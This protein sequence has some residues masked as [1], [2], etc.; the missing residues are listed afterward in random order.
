MM[1]GVWHQ[2]S[3]RPE[4][5]SDFCRIVLLFLIPSEEQHQSGE[6]REEQLSFSRSPAVV[7]EQK[8][9]SVPIVLLLSSRVKNLGYKSSILD[10]DVK[11]LHT[12]YLFILI[13]LVISAA[14][15]SNIPR[16]ADLLLL[17]LIHKC[18]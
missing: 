17:N 1:G 13:L 2:Y 5:Q 16:F 18:R 14:A 10:C 7:P 3:G 12:R 6:R 15:D 9:K 4:P 11:T 8:L